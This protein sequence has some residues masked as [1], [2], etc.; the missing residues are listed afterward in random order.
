MEQDTLSL[1]IQQGIQ[2]GTQIQQSHTLVPNVDNGLIGSVLTILA[3]LIV[4]VIEKRK[5]RKQGKLK[6]KVDANTKELV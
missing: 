3:S 5:L 2:I 1:L 6:D 4:R